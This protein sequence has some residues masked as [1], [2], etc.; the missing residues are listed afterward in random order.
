MCS[1]ILV[2]LKVFLAN[3]PK[4]L[5]FQNLR[6]IPYSNKYLHLDTIKLQWDDLMFPVHSLSSM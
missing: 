3:M 2:S 6:T 1:Q 5:Y 4:I